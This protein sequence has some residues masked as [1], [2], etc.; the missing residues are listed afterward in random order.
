MR[1]ERPSPG[2]R[3]SSD[4]DIFVGNVET[5]TVIGDEAR[6]L[7]ATEVTFHDGARNKLHTH[8][9]DQI[10]IVTAGDGLIATEHEERELRAGDVAFIPA[11]ERH[12]HGAKPG[13]DMTHWAI[14]GAGK[15]FIVADD[16][17]AG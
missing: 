8:T 3:Q 9:T 5:Q 7:R 10:L 6:D 1:V 14:L 15:T 16:E 17:K 12:W 13:K 4:R 2:A 11:G